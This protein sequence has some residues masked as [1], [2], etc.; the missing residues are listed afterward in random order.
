MIS[1]GMI[2]IAAVVL[3]FLALISAIVA[4]QARQRGYHFFPW[5]MAGILANPIFFLVLLAI[6]P[7]R[8]R[9]ARRRRYLAELESNLAARPKVRPTA[10]ATVSPRGGESVAVTPERSIGDLPTVEPPDRSLG[11][12]ETHV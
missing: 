1:L 12:E 5:L 8:A 11:D 9:K 10:P 3:L 2:A 4:Y 7:D 6:M